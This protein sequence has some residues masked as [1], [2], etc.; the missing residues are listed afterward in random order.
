MG[1]QP[2]S[3]I[4]MGRTPGLARVPCQGEDP[5]GPAGRTRLNGE[6]CVTR[7]VKLVTLAP[8]PPFSPYPEAAPSPHSGRFP[9]L[10]SNTLP[11]EG[12]KSAISNQ[13]L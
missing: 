1:T 4:G 8:F 11:L 6:R 3:G 7:L 13:C 2:G 5:R 10:T 12:R 9:G